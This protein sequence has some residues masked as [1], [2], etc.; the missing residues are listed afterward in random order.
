MIA[1]RAGYAALSP[2]GEPIARTD[3]SQMLNATT[4]GYFSQSLGI[5][6][7][8][9]KVSSSRL[10]QL[11]DRTKNDEEVAH[12]KIETL[13]SGKNDN[14]AVEFEGV[15]IPVT[16]LRRLMKQ[17]YVSVRP[18]KEEKTFSLWGKTSTACFT[19]QEF[20]EMA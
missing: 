5:F 3:A 13:I 8:N 14:D 7:L 20:Q 1:G 9:S 10:L 19:V 17:G 16:A 4:P 2:P 18:Y 11:S 6:T 12:M 15:F